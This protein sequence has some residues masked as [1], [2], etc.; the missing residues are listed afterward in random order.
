[1][2]LKMIFRHPYSS[3]YSVLYFELRL[4]ITLNTTIFPLCIQIHKKCQ[5]DTSKCTRRCVFSFW[6]KL[7]RVFE[8]YSAVMIYLPVW[9]LLYRE[10][11]LSNTIVNVTCVFKST[12]YL[13]TT[14]EERVDWFLQLVLRQHF[15][16]KRNHCLIF[17]WTA[18]YTLYNFC[19]HYYYNYNFYF[20]YPTSTKPQAW[21]LE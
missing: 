16:F 20:F 1:M 3:D 4:L 6:F 18:D 13:T 12:V 10:R 15:S 9:Y 11:K 21:K 17:P 14:L 7:G 8:L 5:S 19:V 2:R